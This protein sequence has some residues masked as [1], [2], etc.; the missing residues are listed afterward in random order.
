M[1][2]VINALLLGA[3]LVLAGCMQPTGSSDGAAPGGFDADTAAKNFVTVI[4]RVEPVAE[5]VCRSRQ[6]Q[7][8]CD[9]L[10]VVDD[11][12]GQ[13]P[14]AY[15]TLDERGRPVIAFTL[16][17]IADARNQD[18]LA[19]ILGHEAAHHIAAHI[20]R[21]QQDATIGALVLGTLA[22]VSGGNDAAVDTAVRIGAG[23]GARRFSKEYELEADQ[24]GTV[25]AFRAGYDPVRG[26][27]YFS[28]I[29]DPGDAFLGTHPPN[30]SRMEVVRVT[31][32]A[33]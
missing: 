18:E 22:T 13:P 1:R 14:N 7:A 20:P 21:S 8:N 33:L 30:A 2:K 15:Q 24:L 10:I 6:P 17:L 16:A 3:V 31:A 25:I 32:A 26:A 9:F 29:P 23:L 28:R 19:F 27:K 4:N 11:R 12:R 5:R